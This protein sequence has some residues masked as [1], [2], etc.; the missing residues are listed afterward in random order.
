MTVIDV[1]ADV[2]CPFTHVGLRRFVERRTERRRDDVL[3]RVHAW[4]LELVNGEPVGRELVTEE[5]EQL[6]DQAAPDLFQGFDPAALP[7]TSMPAFAL[8]AAAYRHSDAVGERVSLALREELFERGHDIA[9]PDRLARLATAEGFELPDLTD[10][11]TPRADWEEGKRRGVEGSPHY[12]VGDEGFFCPVLDIKKVD[13]HLRV[14]VDD[15]QFT[16]FL[17]RALG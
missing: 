8:A 5:V 4:P 2:A 1:Y 6:Q 11:S 14:K 7:A 9:D 10:D 13:G 12:F 15:E 17:E 16:R 3:L